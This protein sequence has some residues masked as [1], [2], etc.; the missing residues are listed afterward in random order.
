MPWSPS[1]QQGTQ[2]QPNSPD[3][4]SPVPSL[5]SFSDRVRPLTSPSQAAARCSATCG[6]RLLAAHAAPGSHGTRR[7]SLSGG[8]SRLPLFTPTYPLRPASVAS[9]PEISRSPTRSPDYAWFGQGS[10]APSKCLW[11]PL[12]PPLLTKKADTRLPHTDLN[13]PAPPVS[14]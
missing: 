14:S 11:H 6:P 5:T 10:P 9:P 12:I 13:A 8:V 1:T 2:S 7:A 4:A 3:L